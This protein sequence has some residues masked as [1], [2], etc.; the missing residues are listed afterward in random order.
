[1]PEK[2]LKAK[3]R[4]KEQAKI[5]KLKQLEEERQEEEQRKQQEESEKLDKIYNSL[6]DAQKEEVD[7]KAQEGL[8]FLAIERIREGNT[9]SPIVQ[10]S[11]KS[12]REK[13]LKEWFESG[14]IDDEEK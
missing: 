7:E 13:I 5:E 11:L 12:N 14:K 6:S 9:D 8:S 4:E 3:D 2:W 1:M 10:A